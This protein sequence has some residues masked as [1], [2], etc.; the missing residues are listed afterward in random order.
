MLRRIVLAAALAAGLGACEGAYR[1]GGLQHS[2]RLITLAMDTV[3][4]IGITEGE[5]VRRQSR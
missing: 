5:H 4:H 3:Y 1:A 2:D